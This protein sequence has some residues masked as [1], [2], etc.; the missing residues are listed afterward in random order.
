M[1]I[2]ITHEAALQ[3][4]T[5]ADYL[6]LKWSARVRDNFLEKIERAISII[7]QMPEAFPASDFHPG[8]RRC[9]AHKLTSIYYRATS[10]EIEILAVVDN[11]QDF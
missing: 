11:R 1:H 4:E 2:N 6:E 5:I 8:L 9:V 10:S 7:G 3:I